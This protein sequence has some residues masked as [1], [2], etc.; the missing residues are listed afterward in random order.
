ML[1]NQ[2]EERGIT[3]GLPLI[4]D[5]LGFY[6]TGIGGALAV[7][8]LDGD[9][10]LDLVAGG[11][12]GFLHFYL[13][14]GAGNFDLFTRDVGP[15]FKKHQGS[16]VFANALVDLDGDFL[17][18][19][20]LVCKEVIWIL[21][22]EGNLEWS[23]WSE[24]SPFPVGEGH[25]YQTLMFG[26]LD[27][28]ADLD[29]VLP[30]L[31]PSELGQ[32]DTSQGSPDSVLLQTSP[33]VFEHVFDLNDDEAGSRVQM[34]LLT[35]RDWDG[36]LDVLLLNDQGPPSTFWR[37]DGFV[38][39]EL[40]LV[41]DSE[42]IHANLDMAAMGLVSMDFNQDGELDYCM[43]DVGNPRCLLSDGTGGYYEGGAALGLTVTRQASSRVATVGWSLEL[44]DLDNSGWPEVL[45]AS[46]P[47]PGSFEEGLLDIA[48]A[49]WWADDEGGWTEE[50][51][52]AGF[53]SDRNHIGLVT[54]DFDGD[55]AVEVI[56]AGPGDAPRFYDNGCSE[57]NWIEIELH[58]P[59]ENTEAY[60]A[61]IEVFSGEHVAIREVTGLRNKS[62]S[63]SRFHFGLGSVH[64]L[65]K[66]R[67][68]WPDGSVAAT[69]EM[70]MNQRIVVQHPDA[71]DRVIEPWS[72]EIEPT[73]LILVGD[74]EV[75]GIVRD[76]TGQ[77]LEGVRIST[78][79]GEETFSDEQGEFSIP[80][81]GVSDVDVYLDPVEDQDRYLRLMAAVA[82]RGERSSLD[83]Q[84]LQNEQFEMLHMMTGQSRDPNSGAVWVT[85][86]GT[87]ES[88][89]FALDAAHTGTAVLAN[90][91]FED[92]SVLTAEDTVLFF[93]NV[94]EGVHSL[95]RDPDLGGCEGRESVT[96]ETGRITWVHV[97]CRF[98]G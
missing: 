46:G 47:D 15:L 20:V 17:P 58:G 32:G 57:N 16:V 94:P 13:N 82:E 85:I 39:G 34:G 75:G 95:T 78:K 93:F 30:S 65:D 55:G 48:D 12:D 80:V 79:E 84:M 14:D 42:A 8:D 67:V 74:P 52:D 27:G 44:A 36:D 50:S 1:D 19:L 45:Q 98:G 26:D 72:S 21:R 6:A 43:S 54:G 73:G 64:E 41:E 81:S 29:L 89:A 71:P 28:D 23:L 2:S 5:A 10:D 11:L 18:E 61:K 59:P 92:R 96:V 53:D 70:G 3:K 40:V 76:F 66:I 38:N 68:T 86:D 25:L 56:V 83:F 62:H 9:E 51:T 63:A 60:G 97:K 88:V 7:A 49:L 24:I 31:E 87:S 77:P 69:N 90:D 35:D 37:N 91:A 33:G 4:E 22:N